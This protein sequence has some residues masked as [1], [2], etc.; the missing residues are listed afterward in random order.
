MAR[1]PSKSA[2]T[3]YSVPR[4]VFVPT[5]PF[6]FP[7]APAQYVFRDQIQFIIIFSEIMFMM[8]VLSSILESCMLSLILVMLNLVRSYL[9]F[10]HEAPTCS[11]PSRV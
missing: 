4:T 1:P 9:F 11:D 2:A 10:Q 3:A 7:V 8:F 5:A 6:V